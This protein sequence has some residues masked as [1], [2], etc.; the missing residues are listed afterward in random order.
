M[1]KTFYT[2]YEIEDLFKRGV[3]SLEVND[4]VV[5]TDL[6][7]EKA[8]RLGMNLVR[9]KG[10]NPPAAPVRPYIVSSQIVPPPSG[11]SQSGSAP[12]IPAYP[13]PSPVSNISGTDL[14]QRIKDAVAARMG[15]QVDA[16][17]LDVIITRV[18]GSSGIK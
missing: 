9:E 13:S 6:A 17:L 11:I 10:D 14:R 7:Y 3:M 16:K 2:E 12:V 15:T 1:A 5:L 18:L 4:S 8:R